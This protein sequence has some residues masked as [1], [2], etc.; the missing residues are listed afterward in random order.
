MGDEW[1]KNTEL[2]THQLLHLNS[3]IFEHLKQLTHFFTAVHFNQRPCLMI[4]ELDHAAHD[5]FRGSTAQKLKPEHPAPQNDL[6][7]VVQRVAMIEHD[8]RDTIGPQDTMHFAYCTGSTGCVM[9]YAVR[10]DDIEALCS[11]R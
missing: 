5:L 9:Q 3:H 11:K 6:D 1:R 7:P 8:L 10:V 4:A 2:T